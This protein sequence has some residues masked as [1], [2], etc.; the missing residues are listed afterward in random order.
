MGIWHYGRFYHRFL[1]FYFIKT[2]CTLLKLSHDYWYHIIFDNKYHLS[3]NT[4]PVFSFFSPVIQPNV[5]FLHQLSLSILNLWKT[6]NIAQSSHIRQKKMK[7]TTKNDENDQI[8]GIFGISN[9]ILEKHFRMYQQKESFVSLLLL[10]TSWKYSVYFW[11]CYIITDIRYH[12]SKDFW[13]TF[14]WFS[15]NIV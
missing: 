5:V 2:F 14:S 7:K 15:P 1:A 9:Q 12:I 3:A 4:W 8:S 11:S 13:S 10:F 6:H